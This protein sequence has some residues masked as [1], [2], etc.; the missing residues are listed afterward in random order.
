[1]KPPDPRGGDGKPF[2]ANHRLIRIP[3]DTKEDEMQEVIPQKPQILGSI[4]K[5]YNF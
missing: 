2:G 3:S 5:T 4:I 1:M